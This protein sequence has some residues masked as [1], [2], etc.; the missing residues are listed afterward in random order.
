MEETKQLLEKL[1][2]VKAEA[3]TEADRLER[4]QSDQMLSGTGGARPQTQPHEETPGEY[5]KRMLRGGK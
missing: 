5:A 2:K 3:K 4:L 1:E